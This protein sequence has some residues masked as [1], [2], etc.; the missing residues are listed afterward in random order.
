M[1]S[2]FSGQLYHNIVKDRNVYRL[3]TYDPNRFQRTIEQSASQ[4]RRENELK[5]GLEFQ[6]AIIADLQT[7]LNEVTEKLSNLYRR[8]IDNNAAF[9]K[10][11]STQYDPSSDSLNTLRSVTDPTAPTATGYPAGTVG[12]VPFDDPG[13]VKNYTY[14][15][16]FGSKAIDESGSNVIRTFWEEEGKTKEEAYRENGAFWSTVSYLWGWDLDRI[17]AT[18]A[19][20][21]KNI[22]LV[23]ETGAGETT[24]NLQVNVTAIQPNRE[25]SPPLRAGDRIPISSGTYPAQPALPF[26]AIT[27]NG[28]RPG[29]ADYNH[30]EVTDPINNVGED[31]INWGWE[32]DDLPVALEVTSVKLLKDGSSQPNGYKIVYDI[33]GRIPETHPD[34]DRLMTLD[35][36]EPQIID[37]P[38][39]MAKIRINQDDFQYTG[40]VELGDMPLFAGNYETPFT[41]FGGTGNQTSTNVSPHPG[42]LDKQEVT[43]HDFTACTSVTVQAGST[44]SFDYYFLMQQNTQSGGYS[45]AG[46]DGF[47]PPYPSHTWSN[48]GDP[49]ANAAKIFSQIINQPIQVGDINGDS[50]NDLYIELGTTPTTPGVDPFHVGGGISPSAVFD[51]IPNANQG[52]GDTHLGPILLSSTVGVSPGDVLRF[53]GAGGDER[54]VTNVQGNY[55]YLDSDVTAVLTGGVVEELASL[56]GAVMGVIGSVAG[57]NTGKGEPGGLRVTDGATFTGE[58]G[59]AIDIYSNG[60]LVGSPVLDSVVGNYLFFT[61][62]LTIGAAPNIINGGDSDDKVVIT[63]AVG[64]PIGGGSNESVYVT[65]EKIGT[66]TVRLGVQVDGDIHHFEVEIKNFK[67]TSYSGDIGSWDQGLYDLSEPSLGN[68]GPLPNTVD[69][70]DVINKYETDRYNFTQFLN[71]YNNPATVAGGVADNLN[72]IVRSPYEYAMLNIGYDIDEAAASSISGELWV[73]INNRRLNF[74]PDDYDNAP[75]QPD[76]SPT[77]TLGT[78][79]A[80]GTATGASTFF[81]D[82][83]VQEAY[84]FTAPDNPADLCIPASSSHLAADRFGTDIDSDPYTTTPLTDFGANPIGTL[85]ADPMRASTLAQSAPIPAN[86]YINAADGNNLMGLAG[87]DSTGT[88]DRIAGTDTMD[89]TLTI[90]TTD[91]N[92]L[93][94]ENN[95]VFNFGSLA[96]RNYSINVEDPYLEYRVVPDYL[97]VPRYRVDASGNIYDRFGDGHYDPTNSPS[98]KDL[99]PLSELYTTYQIGANVSTDPLI[100]GQVSNHDGLYNNGA[101]YADLTTGATTNSAVKDRMSA[102]GD[103]YNLFDYVPDLR[104]DINDPDPDV[105]RGEFYVGSLPTNFYYYREG[106]DSAVGGVTVPTVGNASVFNGDQKAALNFDGALTN[107]NAKYNASHTVVHNTEMPS[108]SSVV[109]GYTE[110]KALLNNQHISSNYVSW[111]GFPGMGGE[112]SA[113]QLV[114]H[115]NPND[116]TVYNP[117]N[118][119]GLSREKSAEITTGND[120]TLETFVDS[121]QMGHLL[122]YETFADPNIPPTELVSSVIGRSAVPGAPAGAEYGNGNGGEVFLDNVTNFAVGEVVYFDPGDGSGARRK[123]ITAINNYFGNSG[124]IEFAANT[125]LPG[126]NVPVEGP[127]S[128]GSFTKYIPQYVTL[129]HAIPLPLEPGYDFQFDSYGT[130][131]T[132]TRTGSETKLDSSG[133]LT[134]FL[135]VDS[136]AVFSFPPPPSFDIVI[137]GE[138]RTITPDDVNV[139]THPHTIS[140]R[141]PLSSDPGMD[142]PVIMQAGSFTVRV[143]DGF[144]DNSQFTI[145]YDDLGSTLPGLISSLELSPEMDR[146]GRSIGD[147]ARTAAAETD[148]ISPEYFRD[149][150]PGYVQPDAMLKLNLVGKDL[151]GNQHPRRLKEVRVT[152]EDG[153]QVILGPTGGIRQEYST[154]PDDNILLAAFASGGTTDHPLSANGLEDET[155]TWPIAL[156]DEDNVL[157]NPQGTDD[158]GIMVGYFQGITAAT[159]TDITLTTAGEFKIGDGITINGEQRIIDNLVGNVITL[160]EPLSRVPLLGDIVSLGN[161]RGT[162]EITAFLNRSFAMS[163]NAP[164]QIEYVWEEF[165]VTGYPPTVA[166]KGVDT[167]EAIGFKKTNPGDLTPEGPTKDENVWLEADYLVVGNGR[168]GGSTDNEFTAELKR[169]VD[170]PEY[171]ELFRYNIFKNVFITASVNDPFND[172]ISSKLMLTWDRQRRRVEIQQTSFTAYYKSV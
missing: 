154:N 171:A 145:T 160:N 39:E 149:S 140:I 59:N 137:N 115:P 97:T 12:V 106:L 131:Q 108:F 52:N 87:N 152:V 56:G 124:S 114:V 105:F 73:D 46:D 116:G 112:T 113:A 158:L 92:I 90:P 138:T 15:P 98:N 129:P 63:G 65:F 93:K 79:D 155:G 64:A 141:P 153:Q 74:A 6:Q 44:V 33:S 34:Y 68:G 95:I 78:V 60:S 66:N 18:Y 104:D 71:Q 130:R 77:A 126:D 27:V 110:Q 134:T 162:R 43:S 50:V 28:I 144:T 148:Y 94:K 107:Q 127:I 58:I 101:Y 4:G 7:K 80:N 16:Y 159:A 86:F 118:A 120:L 156:Y 5:E 48:L 32:F 123:V 125:P 31:S 100:N 157:I 53:G 76:W 109:I 26:P 38:T 102:D 61:P 49:N 72:D 96:N 20:T 2:I 111:Q 133:V 132:M 23:S 99:V 151:D 8:Y 147:D 139:N 1:S 10:V 119:I 81:L 143:E 45:T 41:A 166:T 47:I 89:Y 24:N 3:E 67:L 55:V 121:S 21:D 150:P 29:G 30:S 36:K 62:P 57:T 128:S 69:P 165:Q 172:V 25:P 83:N 13:R 54:T 161:G 169:I 22:G 117:N 11:S 88:Y 167:A 164:L 103:D 122:I 91:L 42:N 163:S 40:F 85:P 35:G 70:D 9:R 19:T 146:V 84:R 142:I 168:S 170:N 135:H 136:G 37:A 82:Q 75:T 17:N 51:L 14:N